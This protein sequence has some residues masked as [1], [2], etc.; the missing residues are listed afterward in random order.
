MITINDPDLEA[1][2]RVIQEETGDSATTVVRR[3]LAR[4]LEVQPTAGRPARMH[5]GPLTEAE[6]AVRRAAILKIQAAV[7][8]LPV[9]DNRSADEII[10]YDEHGLPR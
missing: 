1:M 7:A 9:L 4:A 6:V 8:E 10:G 3:A 2:L 5:R